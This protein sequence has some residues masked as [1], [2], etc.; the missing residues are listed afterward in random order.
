[1]T[2]GKKGHIK[3]LG[4]LEADVM[5]ILWRCA[6][7][8]S[9]RDI[10]DSLTHR[11]QTFAYTTVLTVMT[12]LY[13]KG[14]VLRDKHGRGFLYRPSRSREEATSRA[15]REILDA[16]ADSAAVLL[17]L[18]RNVSATESEAIRLGLSSGDSSQ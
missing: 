14:W 8:Q 15:L 13:E 2:R 10:L 11:N 17:H 16:S 7:P 3:G 1:M 9:V 6:E 5:D 4:A 12:H 18:A